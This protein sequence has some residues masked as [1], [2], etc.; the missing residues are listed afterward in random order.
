M[1]LHLT[2]TPT[3]GKGTEGIGSVVYYHILLNILCEYLGVKYTFPGFT[4]LAHHSYTG[5]SNEEWSDSFTTFFNFPNLKNPDAYVKGSQLDSQFFSLLEEYK[6]TDKEILVDLYYGN[7]SIMNYCESKK[8]EIFTKERIDRVRKNL[9]F[10]GKKY[11]GEGINICHHIRSGNPNDIPGEL[12]AP[13]RE[14]YNPERD[15]PRFK[16]L[17]S[18][19]KNKYVDENVT[20]HIHSQ[21]TYE[22][23]V[24][25]LGLATEKFSIV[26]HLNDHPTSDLYHMSNCDLLVMANSSFSLIASLMN[27]NPSIVRDNFWHFTYSNAIKTDYNYNVKL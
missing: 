25:L 12:A 16:N 13:H 7:T 1:S 21:G 27:S 9:V 15:Y 17:I 23:F 24:N 22:D 10:S 18:T 3:D 8:D 26:L 11:F 6:N 19:L 2:I 4:N 20:Y 5:Y 14:I